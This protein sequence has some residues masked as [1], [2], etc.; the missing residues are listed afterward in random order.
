MKRSAAVSISLVAAAAAAALACSPSS[1]SESARHCVDANDVVVPDSLCVRAV[2][3]GDTLP[4]PAPGDSIGQRRAGGGGG[5]MGVLPM[6]LA[7]RYMYGGMSQGIG[8]RVSG[9]S[10]A[11]RAGVNYRSGSR[12]SGV[13]RGGFGRTGGVRGGGYS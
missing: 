3:T 2:A 12:G 10:Y 4:T 8:S 9:G 5:G 6:L 1:S 11:P 7:Y 13:A